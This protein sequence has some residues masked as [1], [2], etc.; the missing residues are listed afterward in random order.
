[1][2]FSIDGI[3]NLLVNLINTVYGYIRDFINTMFSYFPFDDPKKT[4]MLS[5]LMLIGVVS[6]IA[7]FSSSPIMMSGVKGIDGDSKYNL[8]GAGD[9]SIGTGGEGGEVTTTTV[10]TI[11]PVG[12][13][14]NTDADCDY[15]TGN[16]VYK[17]LCCKPQDWEGYACAGRCLRSDTYTVDACKLPN[18]CDI[19]GADITSYLK[20]LESSCINYQISPTRYNSLCKETTGETGGYNA[21]GGCCT[22]TNEVCYGFCLK[23]KDDA[24]CNDITDCFSEKEVYILLK[25]AQYV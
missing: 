7:L 9:E 24:N 3:S 16:E 2:V 1:M 19:E 6:V 15:S 11:T 23:D 4:F 21:D 22:N 5:M 14:C 13:Q 20:N 12:L 25:E 17:T 18:S 10:K 8:G